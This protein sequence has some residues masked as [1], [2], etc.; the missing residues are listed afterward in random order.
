M[1]IIA[2]ADKYSPQDLHLFV[3]SLDGVGY[4]SR[5]V[6]VVHNVPTETIEFLE[7]YGWDVIHRELYMLQHIQRFKECS[8]LLG[9]YK[10]DNV[11]FLDCADIIFH[12]NPEKWDLDCELY[13]GVDGFIKNG[14][15]LWAKDHISMSYP[16]HS[17]LV[18]DKYHLNCGFI[19]GHREIMIKFLMDV[20]ELSIT[21]K[22]REDLTDPFIYTPEDQMATN[23][24]AYTKYG[25]ILKIQEHEDPY[26]INMVQTPWDGKREYYLYHQYNRFNTFM[27]SY[28][29]LT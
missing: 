4:N 26:V 25:D 28:K 27:D 19:F 22:Q 13:I 9:M 21:S 23:I 12:K 1:V 2:S 24:V 7:S 11:L 5:K 8:L 10:D 15:H 3:T 6:M 18:L 14:D 17:D 16:D 20:Y 29:M